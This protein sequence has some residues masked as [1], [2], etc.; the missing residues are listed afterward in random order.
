MHYRFITVACKLAS[1][2]CT[3]FKSLARTGTDVFNCGFAFTYTQKLFGPTLCGPH[4]LALGH[5]ASS[6]DSLIHQSIERMDLALV[7]YYQT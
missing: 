5:I 6:V 2:E 1:R 4:G 3:S 7:T